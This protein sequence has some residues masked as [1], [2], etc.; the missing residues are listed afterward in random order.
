MACDESDDLGI[1][2]QQRPEE[3]AALPLSVNP[4]ASPTGVAWQRTAGS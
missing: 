2:Q 4:S 1:Q 3:I